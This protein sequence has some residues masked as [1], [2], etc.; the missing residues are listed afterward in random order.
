MITNAELKNYLKITDST[1]DTQVTIAVANAIGFVADYL[2]YSLAL[3]DRTEVFL[4]T[5]NIFDLRFTNIN[6]L[7]SIKY[8]DDEFNPD[9]VAYSTSTDFKTD[10][11]KWQVKTRDNI[12]PVVEIK[13]SFWYTDLTCPKWLKAIL[14]DLWAMY[15]KSMWEIAMWD[16]KSESVDWDKIDYKDIVWQLSPNALDL[17]NKYKMYGFSA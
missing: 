13:Y 6:S 17:L 5:S 9:W 11:E 4:K 8:A 1:Q 12:W 15:F 14:Y 16:L 7:V 3:W 10:L 2:W